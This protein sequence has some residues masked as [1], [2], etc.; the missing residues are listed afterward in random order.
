MWLSRLGEA[1]GDGGDEA[2][3]ER[4]TTM[5]SGEEEDGDVT[6]WGGDKVEAIR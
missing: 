6:R 1:V 2:T 3:T 4:T 5:E